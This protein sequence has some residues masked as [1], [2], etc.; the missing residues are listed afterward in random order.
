MVV[1]NDYYI[2]KLIWLYSEIEFIRLILKNLE[3]THYFTIYTEMKDGAGIDSLIYFKNIILERWEASTE[4]RIPQPPKTH[5]THPDT[6][7]SAG[8]SAPIRLGR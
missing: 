6:R 4:A 8:L 2:L 3:D 5:H 7:Q 1:S